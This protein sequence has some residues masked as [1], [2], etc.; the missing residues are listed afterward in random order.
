ML[1][2]ET[3]YDRMLVLGEDT[4]LARILNENGKN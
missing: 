1:T 2:S 4:L 3:L